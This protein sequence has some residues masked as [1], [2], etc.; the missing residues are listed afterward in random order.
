[1]KTLRKY[2]ALIFIGIVMSFIMVSS[3]GDDKVVTDENNPPSK[4]V[5]NALPGT[6]PDSSTGQPIT[7]VLRWICSDPDGDKLTYDVHLGKTNSPA[8]VSA[9]Q[10]ATSYTPDTLQNNTKYYWRIVA[11]DEHNALTSSDTWEFTTKSEAVETI[12]LPFKPSGPDSGKVSEILAFNSGGSSSNLSHSLEYRF[13]WGDGSFSDWALSSTASHAWA[14][15][16]SY[17]VQAQARCE[18]HNDKTSTWSQSHPLIIT[19]P[20]NPTLA[21]SPTFLNFDSAETTLSF[22]IR[23]TG[24]GTLTWNISEGMSWLE[25]N[26]TSGT[27]QTEADQVSV[28]VN[29]TNLDCGNYSGTILVTSNGGE[30]IV[31]VDMKVTESGKLVISP[32]S[33]DFDSSTSRLCLT[34]TN[35]NCDCGGCDWTAAES[36][37]WLTL[38]P[39]SGNTGCE[40]DEVCVDVSRSGLPCGFYTCII[41]FNS[42]CGQTIPISVVM[43]VSGN[44]KLAISPTILDFGL[45]DWN[46]TV[47]ITNPQYTCGNLSWQLTTSESWLTV[48]PTG[49][50]TGSE[51]DDISVSVSRSGLSP[52]NYT[53]M[54]KVSSN[55]GSDTVFVS[56][57]VP[58]GIAVSRPSSGAI[59]NKGKAYTILWQPGF[60]GSHVKLD[61][62]NQDSFICN[63]D[64]L[65]ANDGVYSWLVDDCNEGTSSSYQIEVSDVNDISCSDFSDLFTISAPCLIVTRPF[66]GINWCEKTQVAIEWD[67]GTLG[68]NVRIDLFY[69]DGALNYLCTISDLTANDGSFSWTVDDCGHGTMADYRIKVKSLSVTS[70]LDFSDR[71]QI[72][73]RRLAV[74]SPSSG[75]TWCGTEATAIRWVSDCLPIGSKVRIDLYKG[76]EHL[77]VI[78]NSTDNDGLYGWRVFNDDFRGTASD[79]RIRIASLVDPSTGDYSDYFTIE[80]CLTATEPRP[81]DIWHIGEVR[82]IRWLKGCAPTGESVKIDLWKGNN[83]VCT[84]IDEAI[85][86]GEIAMVVTD[87][88]AGTGSNYWIVIYSLSNADCYA[89]SQGYFTIQE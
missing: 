9:N 30:S 71:F 69:E 85:N 80:P 16:G 43:Q 6:P 14:D 12:T 57:S 77:L 27:T 64:P 47:S 18:T 70:C 88:G 75:E 50:L 22:I 72:T 60:A 29:R 83:Y 26:P 82:Y 10:T 58:C 7:P 78:S 15:S 49:G 17:S 28:T 33:L 5:I 54:V 73:A 23:N 53:G 38:T 11:R 3:C 31:D 51:R 65:T 41:N 48:N 86:D 56:M 34:L 1:M 66:S 8:L 59:W 36:C 2:L 20:E 40:I 13:N 61:L 45:N 81:G 24:T 4:P 67:P 62:Y 55:G 84:L 37:S 87:C 74:T 46:K 39:S 42:S 21:V 63:I 32:S 25:V 52:G 68:G 35:S 76:T 44:P 89:T 19:S 79:Y